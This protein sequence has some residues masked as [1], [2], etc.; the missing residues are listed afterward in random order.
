MNG[1]FRDLI[2]EREQGVCALC[3]RRGEA[4]HHEPPK[5]MGGAVNADIPE[6]CILICN[7]CH[8]KRTGRI[9]CPTGEQEEYRRK[10]LEYLARC[11][12]G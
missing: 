3:F 5:G 2:I 7:I 8:E 10:I 12:N 11:N 6:R 4:I 9:G 1:K